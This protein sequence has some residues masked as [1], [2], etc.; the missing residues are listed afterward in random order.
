MDVRP[1][2]CSI[3]IAEGRSKGR[4]PFSEM[5]HRPDEPVPAC[6]GSGRIGNG[7]SGV[8][9]QVKC[10][11]SIYAVKS[12][13]NDKVYISRKT[14]AE[15]FPRNMNHPNIVGTC[16]CYWNAT[17]PRTFDIVMD[18]AN[19]SLQQYLK[20]SHEKLGSLGLPKAPRDDDLIIVVYQMI[21]AIA[22]QHSLLVVNFD[23]KPDNFL[24]AAVDIPASL[25]TLAGPGAVISATVA[26]R[27]LAADM[28]F[29][30]ANI[31]RNVTKINTGTRMHM[32]PEMISEYNIASYPADA[33]S[34]GSSIYEVLTGREFCPDWANT[35][36]EIFN[37]MLEYTGDPRPTSPWVTGT[38]LWYTSVDVQ[39]LGP[40]DASTLNDIWSPSLINIAGRLTRF[41][42]SQR[43]KPMDFLND[44]IFT[45]EPLPRYGGLTTVQV[46]GRL[47]PVSGFVP[48]VPLFAARQQ[49]RLPIGVQNRGRDQ[50][51]WSEIITRFVQFFREYAP[52]DTLSVMQRNDIV[53]CA[54]ELLRGL[55][56]RANGRL[57]ADVSN[58]PRATAV[59]LICLAAELCNGTSVDTLFFLLHN[60]VGEIVPKTTFAGV[61]ALQRRLVELLDYDVMRPTT[62]T[63]IDLIALPQ[64]DA[65][66]N[67][68][69]LASG[70]SASTSSTSNVSN[71]G[72]VAP[73]SPTFPRTPAEQ[74]AFAR[75]L[76]EYA[77][78]LCVDAHADIVVSN[79]L[80]SSDIASQAVGVVCAWLGFLIPGIPS[81]SIDFK[82]CVLPR[83]ITAAKHTTEPTAAE[84][85]EF[86]K[87]VE[88]IGSTVQ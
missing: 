62:S 65:I 74:T 81:D 54:I 57:A 13:L 8:I 49:Q 6:T 31:T 59:A 41:E 82:R 44:P 80:T 20:L 18:R 15:M 78:A 51:V 67:A 36:A 26:P 56:I 70:T 47:F 12:I 45:T 73:S 43:A 72:A 39:R 88:W 61:F 86:M 87:L 5:P 19:M 79:T 3:A 52:E 46:V 75:R 10:G 32:A 30:H 17:D 66:V 35:P 37:W 77:K 33:W 53:L 48:L 68:I 55:F 38:A 64:L 34:L 42:P 69:G 84:N 85:I 21:R 60:R 28:G 25:R 71:T 76:L 4:T 24:I 29:C 14:L 83:L 1:M 2:C 7:T 22:Y 50:S 63:F 9:Q 27:V 16:A 23:V 40:P 58:D 11:T